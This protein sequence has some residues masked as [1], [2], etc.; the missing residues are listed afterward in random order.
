MQ[1]RPLLFGQHGPGL[2]NPKG[3]T[4]MKNEA[5]IRIMGFN[6]MFQDKDFVVFRQNYPGQ[7]GF[8][9]S[10]ETIKKCG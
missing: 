3:V 10:G 7:A 2:T 8:F 1:Y 6:E 5:L 9:I 4:H